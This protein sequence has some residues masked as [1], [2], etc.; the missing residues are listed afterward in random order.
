V[1]TPGWSVFEYSVDI[2]GQLNVDS[3]VIVA[4]CVYASGYVIGGTCSSDARLKKNI[5]HFPLVLDKLVQLQPVSYN[6]R[7]EE[8][9]QRHLDTARTSG[10]IAQEVEKVF[11]EMVSLDEGGFKRVNYGGLPFLMLQAIREL[12]AENDSLRGDRDDERSELMQ[13]RAEVQRLVA[14]VT[15]NNG[16]AVQASPVRAANK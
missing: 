9:P 2:G 13:L 6:W 7:T 8:F 1:V 12:K 14:M 11:P 10:L 15:A 16:N 5:Q 4:G 3:D